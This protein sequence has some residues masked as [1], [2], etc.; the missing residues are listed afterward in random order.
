MDNYVMSKENSTTAQPA[1]A[2]EIVKRKQINL[3][4]VLAPNARYQEEGTM[5]RINIPGTAPVDMAA[6]KHANNISKAISKAAGRIMYRVACK[7]AGFG[8]PEA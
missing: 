5:I 8:D 1:A 6:E 4:E 3:V 2:T 7:E